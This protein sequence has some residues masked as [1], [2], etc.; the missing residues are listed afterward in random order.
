[1]RTLPFLTLVLALVS[2]VM[3]QAAD[4]PQYFGPERTNISRDTGLLKTWPK[5]GPNLLWTYK[6]T[7]IGYAGPA[8]VGDLLYTIGVRDDAETVIA[9]DIKDKEP[10][11]LWTVR[12]GP[13]FD[14]QGNRWSAG[15]SATPTV[16]GD[17]LYALSGMGDLVCAEIATGKERWRLHLPK[18]LDGEIN[19]I[20]GGPKKLGW[21]FT[22]A[23]VVDGDRLILA[24]GGPKG[25]LAALDKKT[26][27]VL[28]RSQGYTDQATYTSPMIATINDVK[29]YVYL[30]NQ[31]LAGVSAQDGKLLWYDKVGYGTEVINSPV[32]QAPFVYTTVGD[33][34]G[35]T[36]VKV[37]PGEK[38]KVEKVYNNGNMRNHHGGVV[39]LDGH[40]FGHSGKAWVC[41]DLK[42][43]AIAW[44][45]KRLGS[46]SITCA[47][48]HLYCY[49]ENDGT[50]V[51]I[52]ADAKEYKE[53]GRFKIP[54]ESKQRK[55][56]GKIWTPPVVANG[57]LYLRD[58]EL[59]F[60]YDLKEK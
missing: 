11:Q 57:R 15:S 5:Q 10:K 23:P 48:G 46:G 54:Q 35:C 43:G 36:L 12:L 58:Q 7:G 52:E 21:G 6:E 26:G 34:K 49:S 56:A 42:T 28:W 33:G 18:D 60:C 41:Q 38:P 3:S 37:E 25:T 22:S 19:P 32:I 13:K 53:K 44:E 29:Q 20:G 27:K 59:L 55:P 45:G 8:I 2:R 30:T 14:W 51:L 47:D 50:I 31:G 39:L 16:D 24:P 9:L 17:V 40:V 1:M 4:W